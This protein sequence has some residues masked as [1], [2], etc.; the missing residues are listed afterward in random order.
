MFWN[1][2]IRLHDGGIRFFVPGGA[3]LV[4]WD[5]DV[6]ILKLACESLE[7]KHGLPE[8]D[9]RIQATELF[10]QELSSELG[11]LGCPNCSPT[12]AR[13]IWIAVAEKFGQIEKTLR[14]EMRK[15]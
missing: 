12:M 4:P 8:I 5:C 3:E 10:L 7:R 9:Q 6:T 11:L 14:K 15:L 2:R 13:Q 1:K